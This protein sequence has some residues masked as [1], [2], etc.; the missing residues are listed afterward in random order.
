[1]KNRELAE[2][3]KKAIEQTDLETIHSEIFS[4]DIESIEPN[5]EPLPYAAGIKQVKEK[6]QM[7]GGNIQELHSKSI[8]EEVT[9]SGDY[10]ALGMAFDA[11]LKDGNRMKLEELVVYR[12]KDGKVISEQIFY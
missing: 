6:A 11:T 5:F 9:V 2:K 12:V 1:M 4:E 7:F 3:L 10:I 8:T